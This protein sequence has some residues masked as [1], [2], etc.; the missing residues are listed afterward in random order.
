[1]AFRGSNVFVYASNFAGSPLLNAFSHAR[2]TFPVGVSGITAAHA[3]STAPSSNNHL[4]LM[5]RQPRHCE[6]LSDYLA[7]GM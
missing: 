5:F 3:V 4:R 7:V 2:K 1:M 6:L